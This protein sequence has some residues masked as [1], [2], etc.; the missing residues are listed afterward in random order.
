MELDWWESVRHPG[1]LIDVTFTPAQVTH[2]LCMP[3]K[4]M[5]HL[6]RITGVVA[7]SCAAS[8]KSISVPG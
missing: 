4:F 8:C 1:T 7:L 5:L 6:H 2:P 3:G